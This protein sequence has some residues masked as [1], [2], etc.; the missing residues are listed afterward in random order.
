MH[1]WRLKIALS[2]SNDYKIIEQPGGYKYS[3]VKYL[4]AHF[5]YVCIACKKGIWI[6]FL[7]DTDSWWQ[8]WGELIEQFF[9]SI[10]FYVPVSFRRIIQDFFSRRREKCSSLYRNAIETFS[11]NLMKFF[12]LY[13]NFHYFATNANFTTFFPRKACE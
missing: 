6:P 1:C 9:I 13:Y 12:P 3:P 8:G 7:N 4:Y 2:S 5:F 10:S 11:D